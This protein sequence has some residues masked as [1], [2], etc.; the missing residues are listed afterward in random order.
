MQEFVNTYSGETVTRGA[1]KEEEVSYDGKM[2]IAEIDNNG[3]ITYTNR[4]L[5]DMLG[6]EKDEI[7]GL[8]FTV[9]LHPDMPEGLCKQAFELAE[10]GKIWAG[11]TKSINRDGE[12]FW[13]AVCV[14]AKY[15]MDKS[16]SGY[17]IRKKPA[18]ED[19]ISEVQE[20]YSKLKDLK[21]GE[22]KSE[23]CGEM[24]M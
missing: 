11:Y 7:V 6:Y 15:D 9:S 12:Y 8:P 5:R 16:I 3:V 14:Q 24:H 1:A 13:T 10:E 23:F 2:M 22:Y 19:V 4:K 20:E 17:I 21:L 18:S